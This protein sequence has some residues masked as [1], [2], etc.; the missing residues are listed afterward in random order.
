[1]LPYLAPPVLQLGPLQITAF[2][3]LV[4]ASVLVGL[5]VFVKRAARLGWDKQKATSLVLFTIASGFVGSHVFEIL[6]YH[7]RDAW[8]HPLVLVQPWGRMSS[9]GG[10]LGGIAGGSWLVRRRGLSR[11]QVLEFL[12]IVA[13]AFPFSWSFGRAGCALAHD[14]LGVAST[15]A[16]AVAFPDG[17][18]FDLGLLEFF[19]TL[20]I[21][22][23]FFVLD[24]R[25]RPTGFYL[26][27]FF[28]LYGPVRFA[29]DMLREG[30]TRYLGW[31][32]GQYLS[33]CATLFGGAL[34]IQRKRSA[35]PL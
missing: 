5:E 11:A 26:G 18:R 29:L 35:K 32:P 23:L 30:D 17:P 3:A 20:L 8:E 15:S 4:F 13:Y 12:D 16:L 14:H 1:M 7:P 25:R 10:L 33:V 31:T 9:F 21:A 24:R 6:A 2:D 34:L 28:L 19:Y 27:A 22:A